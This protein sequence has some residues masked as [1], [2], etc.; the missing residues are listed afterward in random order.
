MMKK[1]P[2]INEINK[3]IDRLE[4]AK[5]A[6]LAAVK[7]LETTKDIVNTLEK[8]KMILAEAESQAN[9]TL[10][11]VSQKYYEADKVLE[12]A[13]AKKAE[14]VQYE[15]DLVELGKKLEERAN[16]LDARETFLNEKDKKLKLDVEEHKNNKATWL[17]AIEVFKASI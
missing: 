13:N 3:S 12:E 4:K 5:K 16:N 11:D 10:D 7:K 17:A 8:A 6:N 9:R 15:F 14:A 1:I 2:D